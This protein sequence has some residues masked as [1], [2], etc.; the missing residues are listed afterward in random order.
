MKIVITTLLNEITCRKNKYGGVEVTLKKITSLLL[1]FI[2]WKRYM[3]GFS[4]SM[5]AM[6]LNI[7]KFALDTEKYTRQLS[8]AL[9]VLPFKG[10][11]SQ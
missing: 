4:H 9:L 11:Q 2:K 1:S 10:Y 6:P 7:N 5:H 8:L 3:H